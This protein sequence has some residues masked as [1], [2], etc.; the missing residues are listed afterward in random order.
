MNQQPNKALSYLG[1]A[2]RAGKLAFG[3]EGVLK[4]VRSGQARL[5]VIAEDASDNTLKKFQDKCRHYNVAH[6]QRFSR[7][8]LGAAIGK[9]ARVLVAVTDEGLARLI[10]PCLVQ[11][12]EVKP[13]D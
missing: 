6:V 1:L 13:I 2:M 9:E 3:E 7:Y 8:E 5:V 12:P 10:K 11:P 4:A